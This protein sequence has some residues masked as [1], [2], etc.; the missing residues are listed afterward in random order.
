MRKITKVERTSTLASIWIMNMKTPRP[1]ILL[2]TLSLAL[3]GT[4]APAAVSSADTKHGSMQIH[5]RTGSAAANDEYA[6]YDWLTPDGDKSSVTVNHIIVSLADQRLYAY[7]GQQLVA[8]SNISSG[9]PGHDTPT[10]AF[11][12]SEK[13]VDHHSSLYD[14]APMPYFMRLTDGGVGLHA[15][16]LPGYPASH[17]CVPSALRHGPR[18]VSARR[19][20]HA[21]RNHQRAGDH[22]RGPDSRR[23]AQRSP[24]PEL[25]GNLE[26]HVLQSRYPLLFPIKF[27]LHG[28]PDFCPGSFAE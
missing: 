16:M 28:R 6:K 13:D 22:H 7:N 5:F 8:W 19:V 26:E 23:L 12:V 25:T 4:T 20:G 17:G 11:T 18:T 1:A 27:I 21:G 3:L 2:A 14:N 10:G 9:R 24:G 15:G